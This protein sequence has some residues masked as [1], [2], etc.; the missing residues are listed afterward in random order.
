M[1]VLQDQTKKTLISDLQIAKS[2]LQR[3]LGLI[4]R[5][6]LGED[7]GLW[8]PKCNVIH[9]FFMS[10]A[11]DCVFVDKNLKV[12]GLAENV[13]PWRFSKPYWAADSVIELAAGSIERLQIKLGDQLNVGH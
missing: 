4:P 10:F 5:K 6:S 8:I 7:Q 11:I 2:F 12:Q 3:G 13:K 1:A 9:T